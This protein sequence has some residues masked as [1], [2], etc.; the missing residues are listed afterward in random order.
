M[1]TQFCSLKEACA[2]LGKTEDE[3]KALVRDGK[4]RE[5][6]DRGQLFFKADEI[7]HLATTISVSPAEAMR[8]GDSVAGASKAGGTS[9]GGPSLGEEPLGDS[10]VG[11]SHAGTPAV[12]VAKTGSTAGGFDLLEDSGTGLSGSGMTAAIGT[13]AGGKTALDK[14]DIGLSGSDMLTLD[15]LEEV[16]KSGSRAGSKDDTV[17]SSV[18]ISVFDDDEIHIDVDPLG[19]TQVAPSVEDQISL[20]GVGSG[21]GLLDLTREGDDTS[22]GAEL[23][24]EIY[25]GEEEATV[26]EDMPTEVVPGMALATPAGAPAFPLTSQQAWAMAAAT[27]VAPDPAAAGFIG[28][29]VVGVLMLGLTGTILAGAVQGVTPGFLT[30][31]YGQ[32][33]LVTLGSIGLAGVVL[34]VGWL[35]GKQM[36]G[37]KAQPARAPSSSEAAPSQSKQE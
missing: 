13:K 3:I 30:T 2:K 32:W 19:K 1:P 14:A 22:L 31:L 36:H 6:R 20:E 9:I 23:L 34:L 28:V 8:P 12:P 7:D 4:L 21:S 25:P 27:P 33:V 29:M 24:D 37:K 11:A 5:F 35:V 16:G 15:E 26:Q 17:I 10:S 18:G